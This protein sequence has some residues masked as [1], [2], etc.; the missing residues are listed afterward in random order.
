MPKVENYPLGNRGTIDGNPFPI[1]GD[2]FALDAYLKTLNGSSGEFYRMYDLHLRYFT[3][4]YKVEGND[5][6]ERIWPVLMRQVIEFGKA[7]LGRVNGMFVPLAITEIETTLDYKVKWI[8]GIPARVGYGLRKDQKAIK[9]KPE[10]VVMIKHNF[11]ALPFIFYWKEVIENIIDLRDAAITGSIASI[12]KFKKNIMN[13]SSTIALIE[14]ASMA[15][16]R[17]PFIEVVANPMSYIDE[18]QLKQA[19]NVR[20]SDISE[21]TTP[22]SITF[23]GTVDS[24]AGLFDNLKNYVEFEYFQLGRRI[25]TN[26]KNERNIA[27]EIDTE[28][29]NFDI[30]EQDFVGY[31]Q[32]FIKEVN[33]KFGLQIEIVEQAK[34]QLAETEQEFEGEKPEKKG[35]KSW[36]KGK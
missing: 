9:L 20:N 2:T 31:L 12:K 26:K 1:D 10:D 19:G 25:N 4:L 30:L 6:I 13:N 14:T 36:L 34:E 21:S 24:A 27:R 7:A 17:T 35:L 18:E 11:Q 28:T 29:I 15:D 8:K 16:P 3:S 23:E 5:D 22:N 33:S 32:I